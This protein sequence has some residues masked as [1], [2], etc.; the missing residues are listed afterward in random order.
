M[1]KFES[2]TLKDAEVTISDL[3]VEI[4][5]SILDQVVL[6]TGFYGALEL[7]LVNKLFDIIVLDSV[8]DTDRDSHPDT[9]YLDITPYLTYT[10]LYRRVTDPATRSPLLVSKIRALTAKIHAYEPSLP[11]DGIREALC[12][13]AILECTGVAIFNWRKGNSYSSINSKHEKIKR[14]L[15]KSDDVDEEWLDW[16]LGLI[17]AYN[18]DFD[19]LQAVYEKSE[20][21]GKVIN[22]DH[23]SVV[24]GTIPI[25]AARYGTEEMAIWAYDHS[26]ICKPRGPARQDFIRYSA[27]FGRIGI[28]KHLV[29]EKGDREEKYLSFTEVPRWAT[30]FGQ[31]ELVKWLLSDGWM[32]FEDVSGEAK[33]IF[34]AACT[35][36]NLEIARWIVEE[37][38]FEPEPGEKTK[39]LRHGRPLCIATQ[40][41]N[42]ELVSWLL[43]IESLGGEE[44]MLLSFKW[45]MR[46]AGL[47]MVKLYFEKGLPIDVDSEDWIGGAVI[48]AAT[49]AG[50][51]GRAEHLRW[52][53]ENGVVFKGGDERVLVFKTAQ[54]GSVR[55]LKV[56]RDLLDG[57]ESI[58]KEEIQKAWDVKDRRA[59]ETLL[60][61]G[62]GKPDGFDESILSTWKYEMRVVSTFNSSRKEWGYWP[63][64]WNYSTHF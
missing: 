44:E 28:I 17:Y 22:L 43:G 57:Y 31:F 35:H 25:V 33:Y 14:E 63:Y 53:M 21:K 7:R 29:E 39:S 56:L 32:V 24:F 12:W 13:T 9:G 42:A 40:S 47:D 46:Y 2:L 62:I 1:E 48:R 6:S 49:D 60:K 19:N 37:E 5:R 55:C 54:G 30:S 3:P 8:L 26:T 10:A 18:H 16:Y 58:A 59:V 64:F 36:G 41:G 23:E 27:L 15:N 11:L 52:V 51:K 61:E 4:L 20:A 45:A 38:E 50:K 34:L